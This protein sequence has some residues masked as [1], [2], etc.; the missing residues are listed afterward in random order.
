MKN[1]SNRPLAGDTVI[2]IAVAANLFPTHGLQSS[3]A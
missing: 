1:T 2:F 3:T